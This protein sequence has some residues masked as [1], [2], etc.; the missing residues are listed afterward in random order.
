MLLSTVGLRKIGKRRELLTRMGNTLGLL[1]ELWRSLW[2]A[3]V[4]EVLVS[5]AGG[6]RYELRQS[7]GLERAP[8][9]TNCSQNRK[10]K[11][12]V[13]VGWRRWF[14]GQKENKNRLRE[15]CWPG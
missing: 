4:Q 10:C 15:Q 7:R 1:E 5:R 2:A 14:Q 8:E 13:G 6:Q 11:R 9:I 12:L 3:T